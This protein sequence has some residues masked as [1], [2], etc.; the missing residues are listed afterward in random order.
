MRATGI[1]RRMDDLGRVV[2]PKEVRKALGL[3]EGDPLE[4]YTEKDGSVIFKKYSPIDDSAWAKGYYIARVTFEHENFGLYDDEG[5]LQQGTDLLAIDGC[6]CV[7]VPL[8]C[9]GI[10]YGTIV[11]R[12]LNT[13]S[14]KKAQKVAKAI[15][16]VWEE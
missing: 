7:S 16:K 14:E 9:D 13:E 10:E 11:G 15:Q 2:I 3:R 6:K 4:I 5:R 12:W 8:K 1:V